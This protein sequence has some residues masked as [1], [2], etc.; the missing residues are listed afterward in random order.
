[1][2][3]DW[4]RARRTFLAYVDA[5]PDSAMTFKP[6]PGVRS[7]AEQI[8][9]ATSTGDGVRYDVLGEGDR[10]RWFAGHLVLARRIA[11]TDRYWDSYPDDES[12]SPDRAPRS[13]W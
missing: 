11:T 12:G 5:M 10:G 2:K 13:R 7:F 4:E 9:H 8:V 3:A 1:M 6:T